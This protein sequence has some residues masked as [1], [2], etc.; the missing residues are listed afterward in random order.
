MMPGHMTRAGVDQ[1]SE[2]K[3]RSRRLLL[4]TKTGKNAIASS[5]PARDATC[6]KV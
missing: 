4:T 1:A 5:A 3:R 2:V 6:R